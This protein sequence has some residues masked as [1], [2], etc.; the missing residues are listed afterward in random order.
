MIKILGEVDR[1]WEVRPIAFHD[2]LARGTMLAENNQRF[3]LFDKS[4][5][6]FAQLGYGFES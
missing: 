6:N 3:L 5:K 2:S 1:V 4:F